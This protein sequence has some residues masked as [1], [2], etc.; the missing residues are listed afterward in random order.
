MTLGKGQEMANRFIWRFL[1]GHG[2]CSA[3]QLFP[4]FTTARCGFVHPS[5]G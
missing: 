1:L 3:H 4:H 2:P 5:D